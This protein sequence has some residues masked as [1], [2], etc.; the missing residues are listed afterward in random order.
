MA[1]TFGRFHTD[2]TVHGMTT[3]PGEFRFSLDVRAYDNEVLSA[4]DA[5]LHASIADIERRRRV[6][7]ELGRRAEAAVGEASPAILGRFEAAAYALGIATMRL[8]SPASHVAA[9]F[10]KAGIPMGMLFV[11]NENGS[12]NPQEAMEI[13]DFMD[14]VSILTWWLVSET[15]S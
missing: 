3:V 9:A 11:R 2:P 5:H 6:K 13:G 8:G 14:A 10:A 4:T 15:C 12:H 1:V 7:F